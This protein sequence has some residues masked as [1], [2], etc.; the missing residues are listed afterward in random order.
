MEDAALG[1]VP[2]VIGQDGTPVV[3]LVAVAADEPTV[4]TEVAVAAE[5]DVE[6]LDIG[7]KTTILDLSRILFDHFKTWERVS[8]FELNLNK[9]TR[10]TIILLK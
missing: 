8:L 3:S 10:P 5:G 2:T 4:T 6:A 7:S 9:Q 1:V